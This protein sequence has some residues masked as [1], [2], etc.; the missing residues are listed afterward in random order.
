[1]HQCKVLDISS[2]FPMKIPHDAHIGLDIVFFCQNPV[3]NGTQIL[4]RFDVN[5]D[6]SDVMTSFGT[7]R[8]PPRWQALMLITYIVWDVKFKKVINDMTRVV[9]VRRQPDRIHNWEPPNNSMCGLQESDWKLIEKKAKTVSFY[10]TLHVKVHW[11]NFLLRNLVP[12]SL[13]ATFFIETSCRSRP[14]YK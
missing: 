11:C 5:R 10:M 13:T 7:N 3:E 12:K 6:K 4:P 1:V 8:R 2:V 14:S 9:K